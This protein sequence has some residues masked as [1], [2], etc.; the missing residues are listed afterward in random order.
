MITVNGESLAFRQGMTIRDV[1][2]EKGFVFP[3]LIVKVDG[4]LV[5]RDQYPSFLVPDGADLQVIHLM[6][7]G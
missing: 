5:P 7:G 1:L 4:T 6:S 2:K 3:L